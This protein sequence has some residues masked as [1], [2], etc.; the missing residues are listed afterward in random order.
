MYTNIRLNGSG[1]RAE[2]HWRHA[3]ASVFQEP[4]FQSLEQTAYVDITGSDHLIVNSR[5][6]HYFRYFRS[7][8]RRDLA[9]KNVPISRLRSAIPKALEGVADATNGSGCLPGH[10]LLTFHLVLTAWHSFDGAQFFRAVMR[11]KAERFE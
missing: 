5:A 3:D 6:R 9:E 10:L 7:Y 8:R 1:Q 11:T 4:L 2:I